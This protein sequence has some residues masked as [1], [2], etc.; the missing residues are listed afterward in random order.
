MPCLRRAHDVEIYSQTLNP[1][2]A[3][4][5]VEG[6][7][8][9][10]TTSGAAVEEE[11]DAFEVLPA[12]S[13]RPAG[14]A[15][16]APIRDLDADEG[17]GGAALGDTSHIPDISAL[18]L[19]AEGPG[20]AAGGGPAAAGAVA[21]SA[22]GV[23]QTRTYDVLI[24]YDKYYQV[25]RVWL[26]GY[27]EDKA[28]LTQDQVMEDVHADY[29]AATGARKTVTVEDHPHRVAGGHV[30]SIHPCRHAETMRALSEGMASATGDGAGGAAAPGEFKVE[31]YMIL[32]I[33]F[34]AFV[35]PTI[36]YDYTMSA[37]L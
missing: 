13:A 32:F 22:S 31:H 27:G 16:A 17:T 37:G 6:G 20:E 10:A 9:V 29:S 30:V 33:K 7:D 4:E 34:I 24:S 15:A 2:T 3:G 8:W 26:I 28:P 5:D 12:T 25:P 21:P 1:K 18:D 36:E 35:V 19:D 23:M 11:L 14:G